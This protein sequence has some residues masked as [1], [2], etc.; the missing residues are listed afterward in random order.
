MY[1]IDTQPRV[2]STLARTTVDAVRG[3]LSYKF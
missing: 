2:D 3:G 1:G